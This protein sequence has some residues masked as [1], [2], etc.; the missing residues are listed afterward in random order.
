MNS[1]EDLRRKADR[2]AASSNPDER[3]SALRKLSQERSLPRGPEPAPL[4]KILSQ[5][6]ALR[7]YG[8]VRGDQQLNE[9]WQKTLATLGEPDWH[10]H[11]RVLYLRNGT[12]HIGVSSSALLS[13]LAA[14]HKSRLLQSLRG[15]FAQLRLRDLKFRLTSDNASPG[16]TESEQP[17]S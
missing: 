5:L 1:P 15:N 3:L 13:E 11:T 9:A 12:L 16:E 10:A 6:F 8:R 14:F 4:G 2:P 7:G 17:F